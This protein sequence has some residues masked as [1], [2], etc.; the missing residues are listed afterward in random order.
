MRAGAGIL[1]AIGL[2]VSSVFASHAPERIVMSGDEAL[3]FY[4]A[5]AAQQED[6]SSDV[7][8]TRPPG[9]PGLAVYSIQMIVESSWGPLVGRVRPETRALM[10]GDLL[11]VYGEVNFRV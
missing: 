6:G 7:T 1:A 2:P 5:L 9:A 3:P 10:P 8:V 11:R 4:R